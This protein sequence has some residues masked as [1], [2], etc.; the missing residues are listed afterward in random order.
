[1]IVTDH[2]A[3]TRT[4]FSKLELWLF[5]YAGGQN[6]TVSRTGVPLTHKLHTYSADPT[7][8]NLRHTAS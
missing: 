5:G 7:R 1:M 6:S 3:G 4:D 2:R 8:L